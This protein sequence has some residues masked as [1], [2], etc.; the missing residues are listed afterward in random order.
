[1]RDCRIYE[2]LCFDPVIQTIKPNREFLL[3]G[4]PFI[5]DER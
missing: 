2:F 4:W 1:M 5:E 3:W